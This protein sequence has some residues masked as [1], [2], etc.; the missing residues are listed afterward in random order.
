MIEFNRVT[1]ESP[2]LQHARERGTCRVEYACEF[3]ETMESHEYVLY[4]LRAICT[5]SLKSDTVVCKAVS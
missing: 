1:V 3:V 5:D 2:T 4:L